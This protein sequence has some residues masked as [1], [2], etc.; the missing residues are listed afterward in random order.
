MLNQCQVHSQSFASPGLCIHSSFCGSACILVVVWLCQSGHSLALERSALSTTAHPITEQHWQDF[1]KITCASYIGLEYSRG[2]QNIT[3]YYSVGFTGA[4][5]GQAEV[6]DIQKLAKH[7]GKESER[8]S[9]L[10]DSAVIGRKPKNLFLQ[11][12]SFVSIICFYGY[13]PLPSYLYFFRKISEWALR[14]KES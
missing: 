12:S 9:I 13:F 14:G 7:R 4:S 5:I 8:D 1:W 10:L 2:L 6:R 11:W 3:V